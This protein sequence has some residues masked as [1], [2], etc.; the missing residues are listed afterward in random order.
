LAAVPST[1][2]L[3]NFLGTDFTAQTNRFGNDQAAE[4]PDT[5]IAVGPNSVVEATNASLYVWSKTGAFISAADLNIMFFGPPPFTHA[6]SDPRVLYDAPSGRWF[7]AGL[8][9]GVTTNTNASLLAVSTTSD[10]SGSWLTYGLATSTL[11]PDQPKLGVSADKLVISW[12]DFSGPTTFAGEETQVVQKSDLLS[13]TSPLRSVGFGGPASPDLHRFSPVPAI[14]QSPSNTEFLV[15]NG[16][17]LIGDPFAGTYAGVARITGTPAAGN[18]VWDEVSV[19]IAKTGTPPNAIQQGSTT[20]IQ[21]NDDR[22]LSADWRSNTLWVAG[23]DACTP[24]GDTVVRSCLRLVAVNA[25]DTGASWA[26]ELDFGAASAYAYFPAVATDPTGNLFVSFSGSG[27]T[28]YP[29]AE[30]ISIPVVGS[31]TAV[32]VAQGRGPYDSTVCRGTNRW[33]DYSGAAVDPSNP[34][35]I[36]VASELAASASNTC[37][38]GTAIARLTLAS[39]T[40]SGLV[41][42]MGPM[43]GGT[44]VTITGTEY[45]LGDTTVSFAGTALAS[46]VTLDS[47]QQVRAVSPANAACGSVPVTVTTS[48][49]TS[50]SATFTYVG[51]PCGASQSAGL[52]F[53][54]RILP[55]PVR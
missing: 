35:D 41:P 23:N 5:Q 39:P 7:L 53:P 52:P 18:V 10:P 31:I 29:S 14:E 28:L 38:W 25:T 13:S 11:L 33:G 48:K 12:N 55:P 27:A 22:F 24:S 43:R 36:W 6:F 4:P 30:A 47:S 26:K 42:F 46:G 34:N 19:G 44:I 3:A 21:T 40:I 15:Y 50:A 37:Y 17:S 51:W 54:T 20:K 45:G 1:E 9:F 8:A 49:G 16:N 32:L 2:L